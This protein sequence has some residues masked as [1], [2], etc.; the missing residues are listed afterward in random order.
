MTEIILEKDKETDYA[1]FYDKE[2]DEPPKTLPHLA[3]DEPPKTLLHLA[4]EQNFLHVSRCL[5]D[6]F[7]ALLYIRTGE[8]EC[9]KAAMPVELALRKRQDDTAAY[10][11]SQMLARRWV[12]SEKNSHFTGELYF[13][14]TPPIN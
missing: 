2:T 10:L 6:R 11:I 14:I 1:D 12:S 13:K 9:D 4:A 5:V 3:D 8:M 7:P